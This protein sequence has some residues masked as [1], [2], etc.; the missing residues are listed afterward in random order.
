MTQAPLG[1]LPFASS[2]FFKV[3]W[4]CP[5]AETALCLLLD[6]EAAVW[7]ERVALVPL[8]VT[9]WRISGKGLRWAFPGFRGEQPYYTSFFWSPLFTGFFFPQSLASPLDLNRCPWQKCRSQVYRPVGIW[10]LWDY[11]W[12]WRKITTVIKQMTFVNC[13]PCPALRI[14]HHLACKTIWW[15]RS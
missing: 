15:C 2:L 10:R 7:T 11:H 14:F 12:A 1:S 4:V 3:A 9:I 8:K 13:L 5:S 6:E